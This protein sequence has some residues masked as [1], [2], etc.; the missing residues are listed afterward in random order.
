MRW[1]SFALFCVLAVAA[2]GGCA[3]VD[4]RPVVDTTKKPKPIVTVKKDCPK[5]LGSIWCDNSEWNDIY[6]ESPNRAPGDTILVKLTP[7]FRLQM[8]RRLKR[9]YPIRVK[10]KIE[11]AEKGKP[12]IKAKVET[13]GEELG[14]DDTD[15][16]YV[17]ITEILPRNLYKVRAQETLRLGGR[18]PIL[19][20]EGEIRNRDIQGDESVTTDSIMNTAFD[21]KPYGGDRQIAAEEAAEDN[22]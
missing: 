7:R 2:L 16:F 14:A 12:Q 8:L 11:G 10:A 6:S 17:T 22:S 1:I 13:T 9:E 20:L 21:V 5:E 15:Q 3:T 18:E 19:T 4:L